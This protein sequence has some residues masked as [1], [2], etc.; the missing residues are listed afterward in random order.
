[1]TEEVTAQAVLRSATGSSVLTSKEPITA[2]NIATYQVGKEVI[3]DVS[4]KL[5]KLGFKVS[6]AGPVSLTISADKALFER[7]FQTTLE[8]R[9]AEMMGTKASGAE[10][11]Y[12]AAAA[13]I[14][15]PA[16][17]ASQVADIALPT[18]P[19]FFP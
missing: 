6:Q 13:P 11:S 8:S 15:V 4:R 14:K 5:E 18:P 2:E 19:Q 3:E 7:V 12:Y 1:M 17:L 9:S 16:E 10:A